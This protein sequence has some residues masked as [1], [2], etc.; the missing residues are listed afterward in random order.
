MNNFKELL[1]ELIKESLDDPMHP[2]NCDV[3]AV[4]DF[5]DTI[6][7][8]TSKIIVINGENKKE[9]LPAE[10]A[11]YDQQDGDEFDYSQF[12]Q[13]QNP[14]AL[15]LINVLRDIH[16]CGVTA[17][18]ILTARGPEVKSDI[19][20]FLEEMGITLQIID[21]VN[22]SDPQAKANKILHYQ[23]TY[24][25]A[26]IHFYDDSDKN[27]QAVKEM[28]K[29]N[30]QFQNIEV[31]LH[32]VDEGQ[33]I[34]SEMVEYERPKAMDDTVMKEEK[35]LRSIIAEALSQTDLNKIGVIARREAKEI[36]KKDL[37][38]KIEKEVRS[39]LKDK[40]TEDEIVK[41]C[42]NV[43]TSYHKSIWI[44]RNF[45]QSDIKNSSN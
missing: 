22:T 16:R 11:I 40:A 42:K 26:T 25:P 27:I 3:M 10:Y 41:I 19:K 32:S 39:V 1:T 24:N 43:L 20:S 44:K 35:Y 31:I 13:L 23:R 38:P 18:A 2:Q 17:A 29:R 7:T 8:T 28:V 9:L 34:G 14:K 15:P 30:V 12:D 33:K 45:W 37:M 36:L 4:F 5:D 6:A 21:T